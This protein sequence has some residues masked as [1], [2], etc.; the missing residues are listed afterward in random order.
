VIPD[1]HRKR[2]VA[3]LGRPTLLVDGVVRAFWSIERQPGVAT[4]RIEPLEPLSAGEAEAV[5]VEGERLLAF[6][7]ADHDRHDVDIAQ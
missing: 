5:T 2:V 1:E 7:A 6:A 3:Q 4:L